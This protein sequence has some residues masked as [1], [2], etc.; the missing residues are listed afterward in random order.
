LSQKWGPLQVKI[1]SRFSYP[2]G[3][4]LIS[5]ALEGVPQALQFSISFYPKYERLKHRGD[6]YEILSVG[7]SGTQSYQPGWNI[8]V[9]PVPRHLKQTVRE[10]LKK[11]FLPRIRAWLEMHATLSSRYG[12]HSISVLLD[13]KD[14]EMLRLAEYD[15]PGEAFSN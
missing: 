11:E 9:R 15:T 5:S 3:A 12:T 1:S 10:A 8:T 13:E 14:E 4:E 7:Y 2:L 6:T